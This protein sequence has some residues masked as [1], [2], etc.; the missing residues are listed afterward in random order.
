MST[1]NGL[2]TQR[3]TKK[4]NVHLGACPLGN[5]DRAEST[6]QISLGQRPRK[7]NKNSIFSCSQQ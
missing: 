2:R 5:D 7:H 3:Y 4:K 1:A 6:K